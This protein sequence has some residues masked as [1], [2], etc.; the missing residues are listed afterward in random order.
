MNFLVRSGALISHTYHRNT[1]VS[2]VANSVILERAVAY[3]NE[4]SGS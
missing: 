4:Q 2:G 1:T 3:L